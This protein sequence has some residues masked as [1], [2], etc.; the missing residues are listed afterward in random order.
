MLTTHWANNLP[1]MF[2]IFQTLPG[3]NRFQNHLRT[4]KFISGSNS[5]HNNRIDRISLT[6]HVFRSILYIYI[7]L[8]D[9]HIFHPEVRYLSCSHE[10]NGNISRIIW[11]S[12]TDDSPVF[13]R[14][15]WASFGPWHVSWFSIQFYWLVQKKIKSQN[16]SKVCGLTCNLLSNQPWTNHQLSAVS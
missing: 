5:T 8:Y 12:G 3:S 10:N 15:G 4:N 16:S 9:I 2:Q 7:L 6:H 11:M 1:N 13:L 14:P